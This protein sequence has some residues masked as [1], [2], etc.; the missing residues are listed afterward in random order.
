MQEMPA[1]RT[2]SVRFATLDDIDQLC[3]LNRNAWPPPLQGLPR[4]DLEWRIHSFPAGQ[5]VLVD[6]S[7]TIIGSLFTQRIA[8]ID[9]LR[10]ASFDNVSRL[11]AADGPVWLL[12]SV[13]VRPSHLAL[14]LGDRLVR[15]ALAMALSEGVPEA[16]AVTRCRATHQNHR[17]RLSQALWLVE[18][19]CNG[20]WR[21]G[22][23]AVA[24]A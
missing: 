17:E 18:R 5:L 19:M 20:R 6:S 1:T 12:V 9:A 3:S 22:V 15:Q 10:G 16:V 11:H 4:T 14:G 24:Y 8:T 2:P 7:N 13:Q 23:N 21:M